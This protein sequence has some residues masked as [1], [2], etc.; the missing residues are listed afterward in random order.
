MVNTTSKPQKLHSGFGLGNMSPAEVVVAENLSGAQLYPNANA[1]PVAPTGATTGDVPL[2]D[3]VTQGLLEKLPNDL[4]QQQRNAVNDLLNEF[5]PI[6]SK[7]P[8][9]MGRTK[10]VEH[11]IDRVITDLSNKAYAG[12]P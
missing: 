5:D 11:T 3:K 8:Y 12:I 10:L 6:F 4:T 1:T 2:P 9:D 7:G